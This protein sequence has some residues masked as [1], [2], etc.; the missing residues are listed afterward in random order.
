MGTTTFF[1][2]IEFGRKNKVKDF[3][4]EEELVTIPESIHKVAFD[5]TNS[6]P[7]QD[8]VIESPIKIIWSFMKNK[9]KI[10]KNLCFMSQYLCGDLQEKGE[11][12]FQMNM[13]CFSRNKRKI[14]V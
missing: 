14:M 9:L 11:V 6:K 4:L 10:L 7:L 8:I 2:D 1:E 13:W 12:L 3:V 5:K